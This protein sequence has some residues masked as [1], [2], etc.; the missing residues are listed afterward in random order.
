VAG[1]YDAPADS[2]KTVT[3][4]PS[5]W[6]GMGEA[7]A[8]ALYIET[9]P[10]M[11]K[12]DDTPAPTTAAVT[13]IVGGTR[14]RWSLRCKEQDYRVYEATAWEVSL[15]LLDAK[16][17][18]IAKPSQPYGRPDPLKL[19]APRS[20]MLTHDW[21]ETAMYF[22]APPGA[23]A[24]R[25]SFRAVGG[26]HYFKLGKLWLSPVEIVPVGRPHRAEVQRF[27]TLVMPLE[28]GAPPPKVSSGR[29]G[30]TVEHPGGTTDAVTVSADSE[31]A[32]ARTRGGQTVA[33]FPSAAADT[34]STMSLKTN[35][36]ASAARLAAGFKPVLDALSAER[37]ALTKSGRRNLAADAKVAA[38]AVRDE[39]FAAAHV[40][41]NQTAEYAADGRLDY[42]LGITWSSN[43]TA[44]YGTGKESL[45]A[46]RE[47]F[48][49]YVRPTYWLLPEETPGWVELELKAPAAVR[50][51]RLLN[52]SNAG[53]NDFAA[54][55]FRVELF[56]RSH[57][58]L[59]AKDGA[60]GKVFD[61][62]FRQAF[63]E[64]KW[65]SRYAETFAGMLE[66]G[67]TV[68]FGDGW[69]EIAFDGVKDAAFVRVTITKYWG[70]GGGLNEVQ[71]Y[72][73]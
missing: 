7:Q 54:H 56:G 23:V 57:K 58:L 13:G 69:K 37:D 15:E 20:D 11:R 52:T 29:G 66:P 16:G 25:A 32:L 59:A 49:L 72:G 2:A 71:V 40:I 68:P 24:C 64:P 67:A 10:T 51:V 8:D 55:T 65:F 1:G 3:I 62:P 22:D 38:S 9:P 31:I 21:V 46:N 28:K 73:D 27:I 18:C 47:C 41:D 12:D 17:D 6:R 63:F 45:L 60:F 36:D 44:G 43:R 39:R 30:F 61:R 42:T 19:G 14:Y 70:I 5:A 4:P 26:A 48:P 34:A 33:K 35:S 50:L 53:L